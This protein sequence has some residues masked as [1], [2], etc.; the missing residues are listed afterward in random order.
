MNEI[1]W[2]KWSAVSE[3]L[4]A[5][6]I[7][8]TLVYLAVQTQQTNNALRANSRAALMTADMD[9]LLANADDGDALA[10]AYIS[11]DF[12]NLT[13]GQEAQAKLSLNAFFRIREYAWFQHRDGLLDDEALDAF[14]APL[15]FTREGFRL[16]HWHEVSAQLDPAFVKY[17]NDN[18]RN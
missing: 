14:L 6:A 11:G 13:P 2:T 5:V 4:S 15:F 16:S 1:N 12:S 10:M 18:A 17:V 9:F 3:V 7:V 8:A